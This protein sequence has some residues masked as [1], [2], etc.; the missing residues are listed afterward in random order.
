MSIITTPLITATAIEDIFIAEDKFAIVATCSGVEVIDLL[1]GLVISFG[2]L[3]GKPTT[4]AVDFINPAGF[5]YVGT[6]SSGVYKTRWSSLR[7]RGLD[8]TD[9]LTQRFTTGSTPPISDNKVN[10]L[11]VLPGRL[12]IST[13]SGIDF[14]TFEQFGA[15]RVLISGSN[16]CQITSSGEAYWTTVNSGIEANYDLF[17]ASGTGIINV[18]FTYSVGSVPALPSSSV[19]DISI[20]QNTFNLLGFGTLLGSFIVE[21]KQFSEASSRILTLFPNSQTVTSLDFSKTATF[22]S[23]TVYIAFEDTVRV[24]NLFD[25]TLS[26]VHTHTPIT[27][28]NT[29]GQALVTGTVNVVRTTNIA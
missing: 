5:L 29:R 9:K 12:L 20:V 13:Q 27:Q 7:E 22:D 8:F 1:S 14:I 15:T 2:K 24:F 17:P 6:T 18:D 10:D 16:S 4:V 21:E 11:A 23:G 28:S 26:G 25:A 3:G 19:T